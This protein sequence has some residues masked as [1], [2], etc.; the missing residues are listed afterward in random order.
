MAEKFNIH[1]WQAKVKLAEMMGPCPEC[2]KMGCGDHHT[3]PQYDGPGG[4]GK[5]AKGDVI[6]LAKDAADVA[7]MIGPN[8]NLPEWVESKITKAADYLNVVKDYLSNYDAVRHLDEDEL[9]EASVQ[10]TGAS[11]TAGSG[12]GYMSPY[13]FG[14]D[15]KK[16]RKTYMGYTEV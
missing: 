1:D 10:G 6:E 15:K 12:E 11:F 2:G 7:S 5:M 8:T 13:A 4:E 9:D 3:D 16:K 14:D